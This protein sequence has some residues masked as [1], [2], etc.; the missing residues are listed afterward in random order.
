M[1]NLTPV[2]SCVPQSGYARGIVSA[3][4][5]IWPQLDHA[6]AGLTSTGAR[7]D[8]A[9]LHGYPIVATSIVADPSLPMQWNKIGWL[10]RAYRVRYCKRN[11]VD[12]NGQCGI[13]NEHMIGKGITGAA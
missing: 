12:A 9:R 1:S 4:S 11:K 10:L 3:G 5:G 13:K 8:F 7:Q 2:A 6:R